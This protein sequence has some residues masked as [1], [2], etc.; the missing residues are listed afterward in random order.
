VPTIPSEFDGTRCKRRRQALIGLGLRSH[1]QATMTMPR[2]A[3]IGLA[4]YERVT[5]LTLKARKAE[6]F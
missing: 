6:A 4:V 3:T 2:T 1:N 5:E